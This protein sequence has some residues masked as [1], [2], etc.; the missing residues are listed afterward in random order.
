M[1]F[2]MVKKIATLAFCGILCVA[3]VVPAFA[4][5]SKYNITVSRNS[6]EAIY[7]DNASLKTK[8]DG[9]GKYESK[10]YVTPTWFNTQSAA[11]GKIS[12]RSY[13]ESYFKN[14]I[15]H[16]IIISSSTKNK[17]KSAGYTY[18]VPEGKYYR[19][20]GRYSSGTVSN[21][22]AKGKYTP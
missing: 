1:K 22:Q 13:R 11:A 2:S 16:E 10:Y 9:G 6:N 14:V 4:V 20:A 19:L 8:K 18:K 21:I 5:T 3:N 7:D 12:V 17:K 15:S